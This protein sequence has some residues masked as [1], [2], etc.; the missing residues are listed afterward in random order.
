MV[1]IFSGGLDD[2]GGDRDGHREVLEGHKAAGKNVCRCSRVLGSCSVPGK[3][4]AGRG[5]PLSKLVRMRDNQSGVEIFSMS[6]CPK[7]TAQIPPI[8]ALPADPPSHV[9]EAFEFSSD[10]GDVAPELNS[11]RGSRAP[12]T[13]RV[14]TRELAPH[15]GPP[16][17]G[18]GGDVLV[19]TTLQ[20]RGKESS[21]IATDMADSQVLKIAS[22]RLLRF[23]VIVALK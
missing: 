10:K 6:S 5:L 11:E 23:V 16:A 13:L 7:A 20:A 18:D 9:A 8:K 12:S 21:K 1:L 4:S 2:V 14:P 22:P 19:S 17:C 15:H 3:T